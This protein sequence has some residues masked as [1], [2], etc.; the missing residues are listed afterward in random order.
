M[1]SHVSTPLQAGEDVRFEA[2]K[3]FRTVF[4]TNIGVEFLDPN[5]GYMVP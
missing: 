2:Y 4:A 3:T 5:R 1:H